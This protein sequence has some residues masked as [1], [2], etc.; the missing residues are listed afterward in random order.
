MTADVSR[1]NRCHNPPG[2]GR[3]RKGIKPPPEKGQSDDDW[4]D[5]EN[6]PLHL[7]GRPR[8]LTFFNERPQDSENVGIREVIATVDAMQ[9]SAA[10]PRSPSQEGHDSEGG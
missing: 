8:L 10:E 9:D 7:A 6:E 4:N 3:D 1:L 5:S 2:R